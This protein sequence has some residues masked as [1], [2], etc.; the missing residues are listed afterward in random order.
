MKHF[1]YVLFCVLCLGAFQACGGDS[2]S[3][4]GPDYP[5]GGDYPNSDGEEDDP[6]EVEGLH[7]PAQIKDP[8]F[9]AYLLEHFDSDHDGVLT[10]YEACAI[11]KLTLDADQDPSLA[12]IRTLEGISE[13]EYLNVLKINFPISTIDLHD[14][15]RLGVLE[16]GFCSVEELILDH[17]G[18]LEHLFCPGNKL[19]SLN[20]SDCMYLYF[21]ECGENP[22][23][24]LDVSHHHRLRKFICPSNT[25]MTSLDLSDCPELVEVICDSNK[26]TSLNVSGC[27]SLEKIF[28]Y[29][30]KLT[31][32]DV[33]DCTKLTWLTCGFNKLKTLDISENTQ[34]LSLFAFGNYMET[35]YV[36]KGF[37]IKDM[38][39]CR[40]DPDTQIVEK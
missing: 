5:G 29:D 2:D 11:N 32:L 25:Q 19:T 40:L 31:T 35:L 21:L 1:F 7:T 24:S 9:L 33:S 39:D 6:L 4:T 36:W 8:V 18:A 34:L 22:I 16:C 27:T 37:R 14:C 10:K 17:C 3:D 12:S 28:C 13:L 26:L 30:N 20:V 38:D 15:G 23:A